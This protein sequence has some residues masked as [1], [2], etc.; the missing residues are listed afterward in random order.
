LKIPV[1]PGSHSLQVDWQSDN[2]G[3][4]RSATPALDL[5][6][7]ATNLRLN[8]NLPADR[9]LL[10]VGGPAL[11]PALLFWGVLLVVLVLAVLLARSGLTPLK[12]YEWI[13]LSLGVATFNLYVLALIA[14][15]FVA[16]HFRGRREKEP[17]S[18]KFNFLQIGLFL[19]S[20]IV[21]G[22]LFS[23]IPASLLSRP[24]MMVT[25]NGSSATYLQW[26]QDQ[27]AGVLPTAWAISLPL[28]VYRIAMLV[29]SL[30]LAFALMRWLPWGWRNLGVKG[31]WYQAPKKEV[32][33]PQA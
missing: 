22:A 18:D 9:W 15:W 20:F 23:S 11:G 6:M 26:Y 2:T 1:N 28:W 4:I 8:M 19:L 16:L 3:R 31:Y 7:P 17:D 25:G 32:A 27:S 33:P 30:W 10:L 5:G 13:L 21:L 24:E 29:W 12:A 14:A